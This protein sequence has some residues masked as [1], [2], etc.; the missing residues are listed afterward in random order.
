MKEKSDLIFKSVL[1]IGD[2]LALLSA[3]TL[4][5]IIRIKIISR[6]PSVPIGSSVFIYSVAIMV[7]FWL[8]LIYS[9]ELYS[10]H[11]YQKQLSE[12]ARLFVVSI[13]GVMMMI[14]FSYFTDEPI[15]PAKLVT[16]YSLIIS[17][18]LLTLIRNL[19]HLINGL[20]LRAGIGAQQVLIVGNSS[21][22]ASFAK[23]LISNPSIGYQVK[24]IVTRQKRLPKQLK[25][26]IFTSAKKAVSNQD[27]DLIIDA[28]LESSDKLY[29]LAIDNHIDY[30]YIMPH[31]ALANHQHSTRI[32][33]TFPLVSVHKTPLFGYG[34]VVKRLSDIIGGVIIALISMPFWLTTMILMKIM[35]PKA[36]VLF[37]QERLSRKGKTIFIYKF[38]SMKLKYSGMTPEEAF[39]KMGRPELIKRYRK[40]GD[41]IDND[42]R[43]TKLGNIIRQTSIDELPQLLNVIK[44]DISLVG[45]RALIPQE[46]AQYK[47]KSLILSVKS[48]LTGLAQVSGRRDISFEERRAIDVYYVQ[49]WS[50]WLDIQIILRTIWHVIARIGAR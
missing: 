43:I 15:F 32:I 12:M 26:L 44:G 33:D 16:I 39:N 27:F 19:I 21:A 20:L 45:P 30:S 7:P 3:F 48:G 29:R 41:Q 5:Y 2:A 28:D 23:H 17:F 50:L 13:L 42:P 35:E 9:L 18:L 22:C 10:H 14:S 37:K 4:A 1:M 24:G 8:I 46:L 34:K 31:N 36:P 6:P 11:I 49:N 38:R 25:E 40:N 47:D